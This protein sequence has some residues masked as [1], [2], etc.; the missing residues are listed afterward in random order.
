M[1]TF[2]ITCLIV[3]SA[4]AYGTGA[5]SSGGGNSY[6][7]SVN[8][9][10]IQN[11]PTVKYCIE[12]DEQNFGVSM[13]EAHLQIKASIEFWKHSFSSAETIKYE[14]L[15]P[16]QAVKIATQSFIFSQCG[17][18]TDLKFLLGTLSEE[19]KAL[20]G[21]PNDYIGVAMRTSYDEVNLTGRGFIY[22]APAYGELR[23]DSNHFA[24]NPWNKFAG[25]S[26]QTVVTHELGH[27]FGLD[28]KLNSGIDIMSAKIPA[29]ITSKRSIAEMERESTPEIIRRRLFHPY[30][31]IEINNFLRAELDSEWD[32]KARQLLGFKESEKYLMIKSNIG[33]KSGKG[34][35]DFFAGASLDNMTKIASLCLTMESTGTRSAAVGVY[36]TSKQRVFTRLPSQ[37]FYGVLDAYLWE[38]DF[39]LSGSICSTRTDVNIPIVLRGNRENRFVDMLVDGLI[40]TE[41]IRNNFDLW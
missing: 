22:I 8:P 31:Q 21:N 25:V 18:E 24:E 10:F 4:N 41:F 29:I 26:L 3:I 13:Q 20:I 40:K 38:E 35:Y 27:V 37:Y 15:E 7:N 12:M 14:D 9:W 2:L 34:L 30:F 11:K 39:E 28:H 16:F 1:K 17:P 6:N 19:D 33:K 5:T 23:P 32:K 36:L